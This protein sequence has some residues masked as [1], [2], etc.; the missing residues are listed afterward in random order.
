V[1]CAF[2][3]VGLFW[4]A[5]SSQSRSVQDLFLRTSVVYD[6]QPRNGKPA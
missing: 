2:V 3:P 6:W 1:F 4:V 5:V